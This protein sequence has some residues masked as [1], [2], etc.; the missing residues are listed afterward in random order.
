MSSTFQS[1]NCLP[2]Y[3]KLSAE[4]LRKGFR[5][6]YY[7]LQNAN[8]NKACRGSFVHCGSDEQVA[9]LC[10]PFEKSNDFITSIHDFLTFT[11]CLVYVI[12]R[13]K[14]FLIISGPAL[15]EIDD[16]FQRTEDNHQQLSCQ[17]ITFG[18]LSETDLNDV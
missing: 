6:F 17:P 15:K 3:P 18:K 1:V 16:G 9:V 14:V 8:F 4:E 7:H 11:T 5:R 10:L 13:G 2:I 12:N